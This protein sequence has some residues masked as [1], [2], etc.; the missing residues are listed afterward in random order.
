[1][2]DCIFTSFTNNAL[3]CTYFKPGCTQVNLRSKRKG[4]G[5]KKASGKLGE[6]EGG[7]NVRAFPQRSLLEPVLSLL[8]PYTGYTQVNPFSSAYSALCKP[9]FPFKYSKIIAPEVE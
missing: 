7:K 4:E 2:L 5:E 6:L 1:M 9:V 8:T 3:L